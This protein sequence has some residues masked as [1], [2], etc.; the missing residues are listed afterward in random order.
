MDPRVWGPHFWFV[1]HLISFHYPDNPTTFDK[2]QHK[3]FYTSV[4]DILPCTTCR[5]HYKN[6]LSQ[7]PIEPNL[8]TRIDLITWVIQIHNFVNIALG[9]PALTVPQ[10]L[11]IYSNLEPVSPFAKVDIQNIEEDKLRKYY[12]RLYIFIGLFIAIVASIIYAKRRWFFYL[13]A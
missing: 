7:Y 13:L 10:V 5:Q 8:D 9:K 4:K 6:Y 2:E 1:L 11:A 12:G 3:A